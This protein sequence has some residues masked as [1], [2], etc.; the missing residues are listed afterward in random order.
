MNGYPI[1]EENHTM[2]TPYWWYIYLNP[3]KIVENNI[4]MNAI[5]SDIDETKPIPQI[6]EKS[7]KSKQKEDSS[8]DGF[9]L[10][11]DTEKTSKSKSEDSD[12]FKLTIPL[13]ETMEIVGEGNL[14][15]TESIMTN[16]ICNMANEMIIEEKIIM[17]DIPGK[18]QIDIKPNNN[19]NYRLYLILIL[20]I[21][22]FIF[23]L[24]K[25]KIF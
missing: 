10:S 14:P 20:I 6:P 23:L 18:K 5:L 24:L 19:D 1:Y 16:Q 22:C 25:R 9:K 21:L 11:L 2:H 3:K 7:K 17:P 15:L 12:I 4:K 13:A 8:N